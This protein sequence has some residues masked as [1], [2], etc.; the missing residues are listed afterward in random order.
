[1]A[2]E[3]ADARL[4]ADDERS[5]VQLRL[6][7]E[8]T[9]AAIASTRGGLR[10]IVRLSGPSVA[11]CIQAC[12]DAGDLSGVA[13]AR[14][15]TGRVFAGELF[16][17]LTCDIYYWPNDKS[18]TKQPSSELHLSGSAPLLEAVLDQ[19]CHAGARLAQPGE[20]TLRAF[21]GG[22]L[23]LTQAEAVL[24][25][26]DAEN[27]LEFN[28]A[29]QQ[30]AGG[31]AGP[32]RDIRETLLNLVADIEAGLDF[33]EE[34]IEFVSAQATCDEIGRCLQQVETLLDQIR[35]RAER[36]AHVRV[37]LVGDPNAGKSSL[38]NALIGD[39]QALVADGPG[40]T[41]DYVT[42]RVEWKNI[43]I[44]LIDTAG[45]EECSS[46]VEDAAQSQRRSVLA[47]ADLQLRCCPVSVVSSR[48]DGDDDRAD[49]SE[50][51]AGFRVA[52]MS[53]LS[54]DWSA[55]E[56]TILT[57]AETGQGIQD[58]RERISE[59]SGELLRGPML[60][61]TVFRCLDSL[62]GVV[63]AL[64]Q[65]ALA[66]EQQVGEEIVAAELRIAIESL[67]GIVGAVYTDDILDR[68]FSRFCI[69]K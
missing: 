45:I 44:E 51:F 21:L 5:D 11:H 28:T 31:V 68:L 39:Q 53:D 62:Q 48:K 56:N 9:I 63:E 27:P 8:D 66:V 2:K 37:A 29:L 24:G 64:S 33:V 6:D 58:L 47:T 69:G 16:N 40:T 67:A 32:L 25:V 46:G 59:A 18:Y 23:D 26:I 38:F 43:A 20:F 22:R 50:N 57:S 36:Q 4:H 49:V 13:G 41:R 7:T 14:R 12:T 1:M 42:S 55:D 65:A 15:R 34:D 61:G 19:V 17:W 54:P 60:E 35:S 10:G 52:T 30:L 3:R